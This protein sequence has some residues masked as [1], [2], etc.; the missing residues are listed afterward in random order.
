M[1]RDLRKNTPVE[2]PTLKWRSERYEFLHFPQLD[3]FRGLAVVLVIIGHL[4]EYS[5]LEPAIRKTGE[6]M[7]ATGVFLFFVLSGFLITGLLQR[8]KCGLGRINLKKFYIRRALRLGPALLLFLLAIVVLRSLG[9]VNGVKTYEIVACL[10]YSRNFFGKELALSHIWSLSLEEQFYL[11]WPGI[12]NLINQ[13]W[14]VPLDGLSD[15][16]DC[17]LARPR[18]PVQ[19]I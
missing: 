3:G 10:L 19:F 6:Q 1:S 11:C 15:S 4:V 13:K 5:S 2:S 16:S 8:E 17:H 18:Y 14:A 7:A 12:Y 9:F